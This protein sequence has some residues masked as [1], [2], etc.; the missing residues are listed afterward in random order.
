MGQR[1]PCPPWTKQVQ[2]DGND[3]LEEHDAELAVRRT[4]WKN[5]KLLAPLGE[6][7]PIRNIFEKLLQRL[8][9]YTGVV[10][11]LFAFFELPYH[12]VQLVVDY[13]V[14]A[15]FWTD[16][17]LTT[18]TAFY[19][20]DH[21]LVV[22]KRIIQCAYLKKRMV[23][24]V[25]ANFP[26][27][28]FVI[29]G[30]ESIA[31]PTFSLWRM[32]RMFRFFRMRKVHPSLLVELN[33]SGPRRLVNFFPLITH[34]VACLWY[35]IG[36]CG[37][38][39]PNDASALL[40]GRDIGLGGA[41]WLM[42]PN[43]GGLRLA[44]SASVQSYVSSMYW[45]ASTLMKTAWVA[46]ATTLEFFYAALIILLGAIMFAVFLGQVYK[47]IDQMDEGSAQR[48]EKLSNFRLFC[49]HNKLSPAL[50]KKVISYAMAEWNFT[51]G[52]STSENLNMLAPA[53]GG[54]VLYEMRKG[55]IDLCALTSST[56]LACAKKLLSRSL[57]QV[58][59]KNEYVIGSD[60]LARELFILMKGSLQI[61]TP[62][63]PKSKATAG[64]AK[65]SRNSSKKTMIQFRMLEKEGGIIGTWNPY[66]AGLR[67]PYEVQA[68]EFSTMLVITRNSLIDTM[69]TFATEAPKLLSILERE[70]EL[71]QQAL[72]LGGR[73]G[74][75]NTSCRDSRTESA[76]DP[77]IVEQLSS[78]V[79]EV[80]ASI[81]DVKAKLIVAG[82]GLDKTI[83]GMAKVKEM[84][85]L[86]PTIMEKLGHTMSADVLM[87][88]RGSS[89]K[90]ELSGEKSSSIAG[91]LPS[92]RSANQ[93]YDES[94]RR[95]EIQGEKDTPSQD[96]KREIL[97]S[98]SVTDGASA[99]AIVL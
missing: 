39:D 24:D 80:H 33:N 28:L 79:N 13:I 95:R 5:E 97:M 65:S 21:E 93:R 36:L 94:L 8:M 71:V 70:H 26:F 83:T 44:E 25:V 35:Y 37:P 50:S 41:S 89:T 23:I 91:Q 58:C 64:D 73:T 18:R 42:R 54:Q 86:M 17:V 98:K 46:P 10:V 43:F 88:L 53:L 84:A 38:K 62:N 52:V 96:E 49:T 16:I 1:M 7:M 82:I 6:H 77:A 78:E 92:S 61:S 20:I 67:Y 4:L 14:D 69:N 40:A 99:A 29:A 75:R 63:T 90:L 57:V 56:S 60:A 48:R 85:T 87:A 30:G 74:G 47:I 27:E 31:S 11:P 3:S 81:L 45:A 15:L 51:K 19:N 12:P 68:K 76:L 9:V 66:E 22:D 55:L 32:W 34:W 72:R 59:L 2:A